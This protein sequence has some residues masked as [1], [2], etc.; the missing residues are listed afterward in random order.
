M[1]EVSVSKL[2]I[3]GHDDPAP[4]VA[5]GV[6]R[7]LWDAVGGCD[8]S[9]EG[10]KLDG[11]SALAG[12]AYDCETPVDDLLEEGGVVEVAVR[13]VGGDVEELAAD[14]GEGEAASGEVMERDVGDVSGIQESPEQCEGETLARGA[15]SEEQYGLA[16][17]RVGGEEETGEPVEDVV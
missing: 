1:V 7:G 5:E 9:R 2:G 6:V 14:L 17:A 13:D 15:G 10:L 12:G 3:E 4:E 16:E 11:V 8:E